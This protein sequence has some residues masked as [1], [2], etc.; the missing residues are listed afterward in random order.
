[1]LYLNQGLGQ[2]IPP[3]DSE[4]RGYLRVLYLIQQGPKTSQ[5][6]IYFNRGHE[7]TKK[8]DPPLYLASQVIGRSDWQFMLNT[9]CLG[10]RIGY[11]FTATDAGTTNGNFL[12]IAADATLIPV[13]LNAT[14]NYGVSI[15]NGEFVAELPHV[16]ALNCA[17]ILN[18]RGG[19]LCFYD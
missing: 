13:Q 18:T 19:S 1:M 4:Y 3:C 7:I 11:H 5:D 6:G 17:R 16:P 10:Y 8:R 15:T 9:F 12:G 14:S 2:K